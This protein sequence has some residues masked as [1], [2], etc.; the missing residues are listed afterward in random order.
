[1]IK[2]EFIYNKYLFIGAGGIFAFDFYF[3]ADTL[4]FRGVDQELWEARGII[5]LGRSPPGDHAGWM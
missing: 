2:T 3:Y 4:L 1:M 5:H